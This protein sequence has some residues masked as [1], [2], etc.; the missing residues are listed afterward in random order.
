MIIR[1]EDAGR[2][3]VSAVYTEKRKKNVSLSMISFMNDPY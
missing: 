1:V 3:T 2:H